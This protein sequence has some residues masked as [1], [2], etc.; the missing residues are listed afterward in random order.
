MMSV[1]VLALLMVGVMSFYMHVLKGIYVVGQ[2]QALSADIRS[3]TDELIHNASRANQCILYL[4]STPAD[5]A[6]DTKRLAIDTSSDPSLH[7]AGDFVVFVY[8]EF[9]KPTG[10]AKHRIRFIRGYFAVPNAS[11]IGILR[12][13]EMDFTGTTTGGVTAVQ[14][15]QLPVETLLTNYWNV[16]A[17]AKFTNF[18]INVRGLAQSETLVTSSRLF[19]K[20]DKRSM[21]VTGQIFE[22]NTN[23]LTQ[24]WKTYTESFNFVVSTRS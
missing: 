21:T 15:S 4:S 5:Y 17:T 20:N 24:D 8:Y 16:P 11:G 12:K 23:V 19:Y 3:F 1:T 6:D 2:R 9:P 10:L 13:V 22:S 7:P 18:L 14:P